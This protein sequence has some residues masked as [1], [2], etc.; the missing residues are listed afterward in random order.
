MLKKFLVVMVIS[1]CTF[2]FTGCGGQQS[3]PQQ[4]GKKTIA[5]IPPTMVS[6]FY[7]QTIAG[8][9]SQA[10]KL[11]YQ[12]DV[13]AP[14]KEDDYEGMLKNVEDAITKKVSAIA[15]CTTDD[16]TM[17]IAVQK[18]NQAKIPVIIFNSQDAVEDAEVY[19]Y[20]GYDQRKAGASVAEYLG[21]KYKDRQ[22]KVA[23]L[24]GL[25]GVFTA[26]RA[27][28]FEDNVKKYGN[29]EIVAKQ[30]ANWE[31]E[32]A[33]NAATNMY[34]A[35]SSI[36]VFYGL[37]DEMALGA[38]Q[39]A[40]SLGLKDVLTI[41]I[42]GN[43]NTLNDIKAGICT[44]SVYT[45]PFKI[46]EQT[47]IDADKAIKGEKMDNKMDEIPTTIVDKNNVDQYLK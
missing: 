38:A 2:A 28:G 19:A 23:I 14:S 8:A 42:D 26:K 31:R 47:I 11:G 25:P 35:N 9:K 16:K 36:N 6:A 20:V 41:G 32:K 13:T 30:A 22:L 43:P 3:V 44:A 29:I 33:M 1:M 7:E 37:S 46:G 24:E 10:E 21:T 34:Q 27:G 39:A 40:K 5:F 17:K 18:A 4:S 45:N 12:I 15:I